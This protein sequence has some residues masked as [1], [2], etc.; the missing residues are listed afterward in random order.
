MLRCREV[1]DLVASES[2]RTAPL[3]SRL[4]LALHLAMCRHCRAYVRGLR[5][6]GDAA[7]R[8]YHAPRTE[9]ARRAED[10]L[11]AVRRAAQEPRG[12]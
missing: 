4:G 7:R 12:G 6:L 5:R 8:L 3:A 10:L 1:V 2:W 11:D 9:D